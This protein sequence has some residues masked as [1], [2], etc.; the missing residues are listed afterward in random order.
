VLA[1]RA[2]S[3]WGTARAVGSNQYMGFVNTFTT[4]TLKKTG[5]YTYAIGTC[6]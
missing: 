1:G 6:Q 3:F 2:Y 5:A 4:T